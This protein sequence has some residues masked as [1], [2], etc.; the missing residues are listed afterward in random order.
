[1]CLSAI[2][3][4]KIERVVFGATID[5]AASAGF[6]ELHVAAKDMV[7]MGRSSLKVEDGL[8]DAECAA[9]FQE[10]AKAGGRAY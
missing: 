2:H 6:A 3:W 8:L 5:D 4:A 1:M 7:R 10:W 9:L